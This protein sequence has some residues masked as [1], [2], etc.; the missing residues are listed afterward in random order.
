MRYSLFSKQKAS[1]DNLYMSGINLDVKQRPEGVLF[2]GQSYNTFNDN[3][4]F[5][6]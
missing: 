4:E 3:L 6:L 1:P 5:I 2:V